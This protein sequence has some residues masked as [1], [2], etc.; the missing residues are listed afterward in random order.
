MPLHPEYDAAFSTDQCR[1]SQR[2]GMANRADP[3]QIPKNV[4]SDLELCFM[5]KNKQFKQFTTT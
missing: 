1:I 4:E 5:P 3:D 2:C